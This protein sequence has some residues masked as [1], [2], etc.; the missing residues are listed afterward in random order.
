M[1]WKLERAVQEKIRGIK[2]E[3]TPGGLKTQKGGPDK[4]KGFSKKNKTKS[5]T[6]EAHQWRNTLRWSTNGDFFQTLGQQW[7]LSPRD[8]SCYLVPGFTPSTTLFIHNDTIPIEDFRVLVLWCRST[9]HLTCH[10]SSISPVIYNYTVVQVVH[11]YNHMSVQVTSIHSYIHITI[12]S[13][14]NTFTYSYT[15]YTQ[16]QFIHGCISH[17]KSCFGRIPSVRSSLIIVSSGRFYKR[18]ACSYLI[19]IKSVIPSVSG[20]E[21]SPIKW[22]VLNNGQLEFTFIMFRVASPKQRTTWV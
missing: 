1:D 19:F 21:M 4:S 16:H 10:V 8:I 11:L 22:L 18:T 9:S 3:Y 14:I 5:T 7:A 13:Y 17:P 15:S 12:H 6:A 20:Q 2:K